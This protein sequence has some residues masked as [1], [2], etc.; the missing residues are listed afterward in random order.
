[1][2][3]KKTVSSV[4]VS[5]AGEKAIDKLNAKEWR[6]RYPLHKGT[7]QRGAPVPSAGVVQGIPPLLLDSTHL[8]SS[9]PCPGADGM[10]HHQHAVQPRPDT[11]GSSCHIR[12]RE[13]RRAGGGPGWMGGAIAASVEAFFSKLYLKNSGSGIEGPPCGL[14]GKGVLRLRLQ[15]IRDRS[16]GEGLQNIAFARNL[17]AVVREPQEYEAKEADAERRRKLLEDRD[18]KKLKTLSGRLPDRRGSGPSFKENSRKEG[19]LVKKHG[20]DVKEPT[21]PKEFPP[22]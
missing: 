22:P 6:K 4:R 10:Q 21:P 17:I 3:P 18:Q 2:A 1:M 19:K 16:Q 8:H 5:E 11:I 14:G 12:Q 15:I 20:K 7:I 9:Q 13:G